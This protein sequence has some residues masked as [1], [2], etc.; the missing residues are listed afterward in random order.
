MHNFMTNSRL[1]CRKMKYDRFTVNVGVNSGPLV[2]YG[3]RGELSYL[4]P[5][6]SENISA[7]YFKQFFFRG[8]GNYTP[9]QD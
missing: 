5:L 1:L 2:L 6:S 9:P 4:A 7:L 3:L 8:G